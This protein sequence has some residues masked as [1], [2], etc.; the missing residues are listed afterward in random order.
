VYPLEAVQMV[1]VAGEDAPV[2][3]DDGHHRTLWKGNN[4]DRCLQSLPVVRGFFV[5]D[6]RSHSPGDELRLLKQLGP[7]FAERQPPGP[8]HRGKQR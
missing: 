5:V 8:H 7:P 3:R 1:A 4:G 2:A 6:D